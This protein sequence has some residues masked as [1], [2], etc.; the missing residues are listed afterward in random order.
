MFHNCPFGK[1][2]RQAIKLRRGTPRPRRMAHVV[3]NHPDRK[4]SPQRRRSCA[5]VQREHVESDG[6]AWLKRPAK[7]LGIFALDVGHFGQGAGRKP[8]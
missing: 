1:R 5:A 8:F 7:H 6:V 3:T 2:L 4:R